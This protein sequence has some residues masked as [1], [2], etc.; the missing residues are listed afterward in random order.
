MKPERRTRSIA[1][2]ITLIVVAGAGM[3]VVF[4]P[5]VAAVVFVLCVLVVAALI[6]R[7]RGFWSG[8]RVFVKEILFGW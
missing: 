2:A 4:A 3:L 6:A 7:Q 8:V 5:L 1:W